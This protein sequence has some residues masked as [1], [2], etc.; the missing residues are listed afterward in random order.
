[1]SDDAHSAEG[2]RQAAQALLGIRIEDTP[3]RIERGYGNENWRLRAG[4][5]DYLIKIAPADADL[6][7]VTASTTAHRLAVQ[8][9]VAA[10]AL[11]AFEPSCAQL[12]GRTVRVVEYLDA[13]YPPEVLTAD[14]VVPFFTAFGS[15]VARLHSVRFSGFSSRVTGGA[16]FA[17][18]SAYVDHR[19]PQIRERALSTDLYPAAIWNQMLAS[20]QELAAEVSPVVSAT[21]VHRD[22]YL[23]NVLA[24]PDGRFA[25]IIDFD[26]A[27][28][29]D[30]VV[31]FVKPRWQ[32]FDDYPGS[33]Q[34]Y[35]RGYTDVA[36]PIPRFAQRLRVVEIL[37]LANHAANA[38]RSGNTTFA[39]QAKARLDRVLNSPDPVTP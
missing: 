31:D 20:A 13:G 30:P 22:L 7:K 16:T 37:E 15:A 3:Q 8:H 23:D 1:M 26:G 39:Q 6:G 19:V 12:D 33:A 5:R 18:W 9:G 10:P 25:A 11:V 34:S 29:W 35:L 21:L 14:T 36:G 32:I 28:V 27:E 17:D 2:V 38:A 24:H 4:D